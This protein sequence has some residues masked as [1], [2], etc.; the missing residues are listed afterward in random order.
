[1]RPDRGDRPAGP[2]TFGPGSGHSLATGG[3]PVS[4]GSVP[5]QSWLGACTKCW[6]QE[7]GPG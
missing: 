5:I 4:P 2:E 6:I 7:S 1:M 3:R